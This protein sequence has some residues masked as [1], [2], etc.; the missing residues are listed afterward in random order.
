MGRKGS[1]R[2]LADATTSRLRVPPSQPEV[3]KKALEA[4]T[5][6]QQEKLQQLQESE[7]RLT[8]LKAA[9][10]KNQ[11]TDEVALEVRRVELL[12]QIEETRA[13]FPNWRNRCR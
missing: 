12:K 11:A 13:G 3:I 9:Y 5:K 1:G 2:R 8:A 10:E 4:A 7:Q 6:E